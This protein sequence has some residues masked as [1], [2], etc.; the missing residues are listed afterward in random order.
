MNTDKSTLDTLFV[1]AKDIFGKW[2]LHINE[3]KTEFVHFRIAGRDEL[4]EDGRKDK[5][6]TFP[7]IHCIRG[8][9]PHHSQ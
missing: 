1:K 7:T 4:M 8:V 9:I 2:N 6:S 3:T 5:I